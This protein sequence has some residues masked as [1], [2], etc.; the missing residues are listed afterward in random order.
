MYND[1]DT[2]A[3]DKKDLQLLKQRYHAL[4]DSSPLPFLKHI[5]VED[6]N[7]GPLPANAK[8]VVLCREV[9][10]LVRQTNQPG[11]CSQPDSGWDS[12]REPQRERLHP[13]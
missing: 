13:T 1:R 10:E 7:E 8:D 4:T 11:R 3:K 6:K 2:K 5:N 9:M 12:Q